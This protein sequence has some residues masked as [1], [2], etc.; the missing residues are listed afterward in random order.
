MKDEDYKV[1]ETVH[2]LCQ[3]VGGQIS[4]AA[5]VFLYNLAKE[6]RKGV[7]VEIGNA[8]GLSTIALALGSKAGHGTKIYSIDPHAVS[9]MAQDSCIGEGVSG[10]GAPDIKYY[11]GQGK[12]NLQFYDNIKEWKVDDIVIPICDYSELAYKNFDN[13]IGNVKGWNKDIG[14]LW[15]DG[16]HRYNY[17][18]L[19]I[20]LWAKHVVSG[21][22]IVM[23][24]YVYP[25]VKRAVTELISGNPRYIN[26]KGCGVDPIVNVTVK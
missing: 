18:R 6:V 21:G 10:V 16:D 19:D 8:K 1:A 14:L 17:V 26:F 9:R 13:G 12:G 24:D 20:E 5:A 25:G 11:T 2:K 7:I 23:H 3:S 22:M 15:I 4:L